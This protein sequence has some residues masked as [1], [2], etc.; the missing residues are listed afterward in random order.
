MMVPLL[1]LSLLCLPQDATQPVAKPAVARPAAAKSAAAKPDA[2]KLKARIHA[3]R[4]SLLLGGDRVRKAESE[5]LDFY[6]RRIKRVDARLDAVAAEQ[7][8][9][10]AE[11]GVVLERILRANSL[12]A[13]RASVAEASRLRG[14]I[15]GLEAETDD[16]NKGRNRFLQAIALVRDRGRQRQRLAARVDSQGQPDLLTAPL[17]GIGLAP[18][19]VPGNVAILSEPGLVE[20][21]LSR[22]PRRAREIILELH[23]EEYWRRWP[24]RPPAKI[25]RRALPFPLPDFPGQ[26]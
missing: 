14:Q 13:R 24:L 8:E 3:M 17:P 5:A 6:H 11:Y 16:L 20:D 21:L 22:D 9:K 1:S 10:A 26:R 15:H 12:S 23:P 4:M 2:T 7:A 19:P 18:E 25:L